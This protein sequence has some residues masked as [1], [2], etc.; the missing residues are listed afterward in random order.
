MKQWE[1]WKIDLT[2]VIDASTLIQ[3][4]ENNCNSEFCIIVTGQ[5]FL[6]AFHAPTILPVYI[7][8]K[9]N[10]STVPIEGTKLTGLFCESFIIC[11]QILTIHK[12]IFIKK[13]GIAPEHLKSKIQ[14]KIFDYFKE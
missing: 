12:D 9:V 8:H 5:S 14:K 2:K 4:S 1:I 6:D 13:L 10:H 7:N 3:V 11:D